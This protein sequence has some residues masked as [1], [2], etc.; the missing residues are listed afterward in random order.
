VK[1]GIKEDEWVLLVN[2]LGSI[3][4][5]QDLRLDCV[6]GSRNFHPFQA[7]A[8]AANNAQSLCKLRFVDIPEI[9][10]TIHLG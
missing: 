10:L 4:G 9:F 6:S 1:F 2:V 8:D 3:K 5:I 7:F